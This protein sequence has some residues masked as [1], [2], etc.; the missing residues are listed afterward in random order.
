ME[1]QFE[2]GYGNLNVQQERCIIPHLAHW[3]LCGRGSPYYPSIMCPLLFHIKQILRHAMYL[4]IRFGELVPHKAPGQVKFILHFPCYIGIG[5]Y[6]EPL[7]VLQLTASKK[8]GVLM[9]HPLC[10]EKE[11]DPVNP[12]VVHNY[13]PSPHCFLLFHCK[14]VSDQNMICNKCQQAPHVIFPE[15]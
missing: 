15:P 4:A 11:T 14:G 6:G 3:H 9:M 7:H 10:C 2:V 8:K 12:C 5:Q 1:L 13:P